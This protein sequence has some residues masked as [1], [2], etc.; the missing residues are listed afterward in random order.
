MKKNEF[1]FAKWLTN[2]DIE[3]ILKLNEIELNKD[4]PSPIS[5]FVDDDGFTTI[6]VKGRKIDSETKA[7]N[8]VISK[9]SQSMAFG[10]GINNYDIA[11]T[12]F[13]IDDYTMV[14][15]SLSLFGEE[16]CIE[17]N[18]KLT[19]N[20]QQYMQ[21]KFGEFYKS[22]KSAYIKRL[23]R[24]AKKQQEQNEEQL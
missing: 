18:K 15:F 14:E 7:A 16:Q 8:S 21:K 12:I 6:I 24:E 13:E 22:R 11:N 23:N 4:F 20:Y 1:C 5:R 17:Y 2:K 10:M 3:N 9:I 19:K